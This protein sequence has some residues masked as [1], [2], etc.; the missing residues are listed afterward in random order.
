MEHP[1]LLLVLHAGK[2]IEPDFHFW[3][4]L[5][6]HPQIPT[7]ILP[8]TVPFS[9]CN[10][11]ISSMPQVPKLPQATQKP[12]PSSQVALTPDLFLFNCFCST[13]FSYT[14]GLQCIHIHSYS[15]SVDLLERPLIKGTSGRSFPQELDRHQGSPGCRFV[16]SN[17]WTALCWVYDWVGCLEE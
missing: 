7:F 9:G 1:V 3:L 15:C 14:V 12:A 17:F 13:V 4:Q 6:G 5:T 2:N 16:I 10:L 8:P 11:L